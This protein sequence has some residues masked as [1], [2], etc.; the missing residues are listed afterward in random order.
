MTEG[1]NPI[2][3]LSL[4]TSNELKDILKNNVNVEHGDVVERKFEVEFR[5]QSEVTEK[6]YLHIRG[7]RDHYSHKGKWSYFLMLIMFCMIAFQSVLLGMVGGG[8]WDFSKYKWLLPLL[9][10][11]NLGQIVG[12]A[13]F[14]VRSLFKDLGGK[15]D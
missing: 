12:L 5:K 9:L 15:N 1:S 8:L 11:Q 4:P 3:S 7:L 14:V 13:V 2:P 6:E 10:A